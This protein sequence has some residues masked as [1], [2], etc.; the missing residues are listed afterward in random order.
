MQYSTSF[1]FPHGLGL[2]VLQVFELV[3]F[4]PFWFGHPTWYEYLYGRLE[5][6]SIL[7][8]GSQA[9]ILGT[10]VTVGGAMI[11]T[12]I[13]GPM[14]NLPWTKGSQPSA[15]SGG[16]ATHQSPLKGSLM[17]A[18][19]CICWSAFITLQ[20]RN[21]FFFGLWSLELVMM[22]TRCQWR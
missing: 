18:T 5:K 9:K 6:V 15:S 10:I 17:I 19:G 11:M 8:R 7:K 22:L 12:F 16:S 4:N 20:V 14:L 2:Q 13:R 3:L 1:F 21:G